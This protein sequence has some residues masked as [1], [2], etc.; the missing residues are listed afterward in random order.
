MFV[1]GRWA[2][3]FINTAGSVEDELEA[4]KMLASWVKKLQGR[5][6]GTSGQSAV[7][8]S[9]A[10]KR[11]E[12]AVGKAAARAG[13]GPDPALEK[14][15]W[16]IA[17]L[18]R[19]NLFH[20]IDA[21]IAGIEKELRRQRGIVPVVLESAQPVDGGL[22]EKLAGAVK[23]RTGAK[24]VRI[25]KRLNPGLIG[26]F[27]LYIGDEVIDASVRLQLQKMAANLALSFG[28]AETADGGR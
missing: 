11:L 4:L 28:M 18:V 14:A 16:F 10:A 17:L 20:H 26:G 13:T 25:E 5:A 19:K 8:G 12:E 15:A 21:I 9:S 24:E 22:E 23:R 6:F 3:A 1:P 2:A 27:R 7:F